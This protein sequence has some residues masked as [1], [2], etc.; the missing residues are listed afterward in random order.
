MH[1]D[2]DKTLMSVDVSWGG[3]KENLS[4]ESLSVGIGRIILVCCGR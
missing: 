2:T 4:C 1:S 3:K